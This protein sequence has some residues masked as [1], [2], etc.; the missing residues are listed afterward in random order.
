MKESRCTSPEKSALVNA[1]GHPE[2]LEQERRATGP[3]SAGKDRGS[4]D[5]IVSGRWRSTTR[6]CILESIREGTNLT[7]GA[8]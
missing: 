8:G 1:K 4:L 7:V 6:V 2:V 5:K 3:G